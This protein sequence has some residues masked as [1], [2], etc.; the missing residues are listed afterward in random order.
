MNSFFNTLPCPA[1]ERLSIY[2]WNV[3]DW[4]CLCGRTPNL[5]HLKIIY[6]VGENLGVNLHPTTTTTLISGPSYLTDLDIIFGYNAVSLEP[7]EWLISQCQ[8]SLK[9]FTLSSSDFNKIDGKRLE[10]LLE[11]CRK[12]TKLSFDIDFDSDEIDM[13]EILRQFH[14]DWWLDVNRPPV[15][16]HQN[17]TGRILIVTMPCTSMKYVR[18]AADPNMWLLNKGQLGSSLIHFSKVTS[19]SISNNNQQPITLDLLRLI[20][21]MFPSS[22]L[23]LKFTFWNFHQ[24]QIL[25]E[26]VSF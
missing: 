11:P 23:C 19:I 2:V 1:I 16:L 12:L 10:T 24:S 3:Q 5:T 8:S 13:M 9:R 15:F 18:L 17:N 14:T 20:S 26:Q 7:I 6:D 4:I 21:Q 22:N 25:Y